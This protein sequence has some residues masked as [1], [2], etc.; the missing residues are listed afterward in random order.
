M[1]FRWKVTLIPIEL[2]N[3]VSYFYLATSGSF[4]L[5]H[6]NKEIPMIMSLAKREI[7]EYVRRQIEHFF[8]DAHRPGPAIDLYID[9]TLDRVKYCFAAVYDKYFK[10]GKDT[11]FNHLNTD[12]YAMF[13]YFLSNTL[14]RNGADLRLCEKLFYL[15]KALNGIDVFFSVELPNIFLFTHPIGTVLG[16]GRYSDYF[17]V[18][19][20][21][22]IGSNH[23]EYPTL[24]QYVAL[25]QDSSILGRCTIGDRCKISA[26]SV[27]MDMN[28]EPNSIYIG[29]PGQFTIKPCRHPDQIWDSDRHVE[30]RKE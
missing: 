29:K 13:L 1:V 24:G 8:P 15:N 6:N 2:R 28:L 10:R 22:T 3:W 17:S 20:N 26:D 16:H 30:E 14:Y 7:V 5:R 11:V 9:L 19:Q 27:I 4:L 21:C 18:H 25:Y 23:G 12:H